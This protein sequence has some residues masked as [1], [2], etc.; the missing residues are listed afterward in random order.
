M[1]MLQG[2]WLSGEMAIFSGNFY[3][4]NS[5]NIDVWILHKDKKY[6]VLDLICVYQIYQNWLRFKGIIGKNFHKQNSYSEKTEL[7]FSADKL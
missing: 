3:L 4:N 1:F 6:T 5:K 2:R 7:H